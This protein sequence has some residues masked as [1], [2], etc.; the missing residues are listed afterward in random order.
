M[1]YSVCKK[2]VKTAI[3]SCAGNNPQ[4]LIFITSWRLLMVITF[5]RPFFRADDTADI[6][7]LIIPLKRLS[8]KAHEKVSDR[9]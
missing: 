9:T 7:D 6:Y 4:L 2:C 8:E 5:L 3:G 1:C